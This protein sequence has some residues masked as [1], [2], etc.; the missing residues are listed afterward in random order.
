MD[1][2]DPVPLA[3]GLDEALIGIG[4]RCGQPDIA[5]YDVDKVIRILMDRDGMDRDDA[6]EFFSFNIEGAWVGEQTPIW[7]RS[8]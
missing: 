6:V 5:A 3:D 8:Q 7:V 4:S 2:D 1:D